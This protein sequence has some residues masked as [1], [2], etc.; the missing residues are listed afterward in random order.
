MWVTRA[1]EVLVGARAYTTLC[2]I[3][4]LAVVRLNRL[5][6][7]VADATDLAGLKLEEAQALHNDLNEVDNVR[8]ATLVLADRK[9]INRWPY[10][11]FWFRRLKRRSQRIHE[12]LEGVELSLNEDFRQVVQDA[13]GELKPTGKDWRSSFAAMQD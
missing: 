12:L 3:E 4:P 6:E 2:L 7:T 9:G 11:R 5:I 10:H 1:R 13:I 8:S